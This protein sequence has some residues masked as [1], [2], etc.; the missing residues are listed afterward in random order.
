M[1]GKPMKYM[2]EYTIRSAGLSFD[3]N[4]TGGEALLTAFSKWK[5]EE[6]KGLTI[7]AFVSDLAG[8][9]GFI[10]VETNDPKAITAFA[11]K[12]NYW[13]DVK[14]T[15]VLDVG[16]VVPIAAGALDWARKASKS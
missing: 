10:L 4:I 9:G 15:P 14:I 11:A 6:E 16:E 8:T 2:C 12:Y 3:Q 5:P 13:N 1:E 7:H